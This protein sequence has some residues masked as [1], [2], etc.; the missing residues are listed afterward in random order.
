MAAAWV[1]PAITG[2][3]TRFSSQPK[4]PNPNSSCS[5][6]DISAS[7]TAR[8]THCALPGSARPTRDAPINRLVSAVGPTPR[9]VDELHSTATNAGSRDA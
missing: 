4:R 2:E 3:L 5:A 9:R 8:L 7:H 1:N 6:P